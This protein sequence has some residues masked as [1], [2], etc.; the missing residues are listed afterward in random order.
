MA[1]S[2]KQIGGFEK[3]ETELQA[4]DRKATAAIA[5]T[6]RKIEKGKTD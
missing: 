6:G 2:K 5:E 3:R 1:A 4:K